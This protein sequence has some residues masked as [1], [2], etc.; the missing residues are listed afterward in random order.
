MDLT[1]GPGTLTTRCG[2]WSVLIPGPGWLC[3]AARV[4]VR[5]AGSVP[6]FSRPSRG[7]LPMEPRPAPRQH[8]HGNERGRARVGR[9]QFD[10]YG[11]AASTRLSSPNPLRS[12]RFGR[13]A[14]RG[15]ARCWSETTLQACDLPPDAHGNPGV[16]WRSPLIESA[17]RGVP[18]GLLADARFGVSVRGRLP[19]LVPPLAPCVRL[20]QPDLQPW[21][22]YVRRDWS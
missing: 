1:P 5:G 10:D 8:L 12:L 16:K 20:S 11:W 15:R 2:D 7:R 9:S 21:H 19:P 13:E 4:R 22:E 14:N 17:T 18:A 6:R 3:R